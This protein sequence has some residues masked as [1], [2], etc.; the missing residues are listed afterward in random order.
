MIFL[1]T[2]VALGVAA[3]AAILI[4]RSIGAG[5]L[6]EAKRVTGTSAM[7]FAATSVILAIA[8]MA[9]AKPLMALIGTPPESAAQATAYM[10]VALLALPGIYMYVLVTSVLRGAGDAKSPLY[11]MLICVALDAVLN[12][13]LIFGVGPLPGAG[14]VGSAFAMFLAYAVSLTAL[15][16]HVYWRQHPL[17]FRKGELSLLRL[18]VFILRMLVRSGIP[19]GAEL[20]VY[21]WSNV[22][23]IMLVNRFGVDTIAAFGALL[24]IWTYVQM[25]AVAISMAIATMAALN[26]GGQQWDRV[27]SVGRVGVIYSIVFTGVI[28]VIVCVL[29][30]YLYRL[31]LPE[32]SPAIYVASHINKVV[33]WSFVFLGISIV[34]FGVT[35]ATGAVLVPLF[36]YTLTLLVVRFPLAAILFDRWQADAIW[37]SLSI[38]SVLAA[39][40]AVL[41]YRYGRWQSPQCKFA[42]PTEDLAR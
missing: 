1:L 8:G 37:W 11:F 42:V 9:L 26:I 10:R 28:V 14:I 31:F 25:P 21:A 3:A 29:D 12:P 38:S 2:A 27:R 33:A 22:L 7:F 19:M 32:G 4:G 6:I 35:R 34:L 18:D 15:I 36:V 30:T 13:L 23:V 24:Q 41:Y 17:C 40:L 39:V 5:N 16:S 20:L